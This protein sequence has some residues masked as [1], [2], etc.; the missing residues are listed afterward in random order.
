LLPVLQNE[1]QQQK[2]DQ[3]EECGSHPHATKACPLHTPVA[4][5][6]TRWLALGDDAGPGVFTLVGRCH[7][8]SHP[9]SARAS[10]VDRSRAGPAESFV[11]LTCTFPAR[12]AV[13]PWTW[14]RTGDSRRAHVTASGVRADLR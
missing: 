4:W 6:G 1:D 11:V 7:E 3:G 8:G 14:C 9:S 12:P 13:I 2:Q 5:R 10:H